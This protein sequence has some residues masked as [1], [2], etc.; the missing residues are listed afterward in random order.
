MDAK[1]P[2]NGPRRPPRNPGDNA[3]RFCI[4]GHV[5][6]RRLHNWSKFFYHAPLFQSRSVRENAVA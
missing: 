5:K 6:F 3:G 1:Q 2:R 4:D